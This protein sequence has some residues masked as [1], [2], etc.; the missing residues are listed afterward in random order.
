M[1]RS[2]PPALT[3]LTTIVSPLTTSTTL[4]TKVSLSLVWPVFCVW[5]RRQQQQQGSVCQMSGH[6]AH[7]Y[8]ACTSCAVDACR[9]FGCI[10]IHVWRPER[11]VLLQDPE[12]SSYVCRLV[13]VGLKPQPNP[14]TPQTPEPKKPLS[15]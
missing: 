3:S 7:C 6:S 5:H 11:H 15:H 2:A 12:L 14:W 9:C 13:L 4:P 1:R 8:G 10:E